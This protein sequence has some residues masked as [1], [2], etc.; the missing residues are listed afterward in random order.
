MI[1][2]S[3]KYNKNYY[4]CILRIWNIIKLF[5]GVG[6]IIDG[7]SFKIENKKLYRFDNGMW[8]VLPLMS[9]NR[10]KIYMFEIELKNSL[11]VM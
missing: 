2:K 8:R 5:D 1:N 3:Y 6:F 9:I 10:N 4:D 11:G 7:I